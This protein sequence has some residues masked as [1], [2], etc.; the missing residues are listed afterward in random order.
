M[1]GTLEYC[2]HIAGGIIT[3][4]QTTSLIFSFDE[5]SMLWE[6]QECFR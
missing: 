6:Y 3:Y 2:S 5:D 1:K 4:T